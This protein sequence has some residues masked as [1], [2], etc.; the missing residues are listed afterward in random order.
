M[1][2]YNYNTQDEL[3]HYGILGM[4]WGVRRFQNPDG[5][6][7]EAGR[8]RLGQQQ[9]RLNKKYISKAERKKGHA[10]YAKESLND[11][12]TNGKE[13]DTFK[14]LYQLQD[15]DE[16]IKLASDRIK[17]SSEMSDFEKLNGIAAVFNQRQD[18]HSITSQLNPGD[19]AAKVAKVALKNWAMS[20]VNVNDY[21]EHLAKDQFLENSIK[22]FENK[23]T[24]GIAAAKKWES[25]S[26]AVMNI[27]FDELA[28]TS[29]YKEIKKAIS[30]TRKS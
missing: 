14:R 20:D 28:K 11:L 3:Y 18:V 5:S 9:K 17:N 22:N 26:T 6:L 27:N 24:S 10:K 8:K 1:W 16:K 12:K 2:Q 29:S 4:R 19:G 15:R 25:R 21:T 13:S 30:N 7:T 23:Y